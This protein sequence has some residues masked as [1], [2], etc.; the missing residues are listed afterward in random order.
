MFYFFVRCYILYF[1]LHSN[2]LDSSLGRDEQESSSRTAQPR[3]LEGHPQKQGGRTRSSQSLSTSYFS[4]T[5]W[6]ITWV[7]S[8]FLPVFTPPSNKSSSPSWQLMKQ[9]LLHPNW[10]IFP[11]LKFLPLLNSWPGR[12]FDVHQVGWVNQLAEVEGRTGFMWLQVRT[13]IWDWGS[14]LSSAAD[15][16]THLGEGI[17][18][19]FTCCLYRKRI[20]LLFC[21]CFLSHWS[22]DHLLLCLQ[23]LAL[24]T[25]PVWLESCK[26]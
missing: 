4:L 9:N 14:V 22:R 12:G 2:F 24:Q 18:S 1:A 20:I 13:G 5:S 26:C 10:T 21:S 11:P 8:H 17:Y 7:S 23:S 3:S 16:F 6:K 25:G 15:N 19:L